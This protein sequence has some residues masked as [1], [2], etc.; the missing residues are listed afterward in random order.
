MKQIHFKILLSLPT[1]SPSPLETVTT[2]AA[3]DRMGGY[4]SKIGSLNVWEYV[5]SM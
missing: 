2:P 4:Q 5:R 3:C 1:I